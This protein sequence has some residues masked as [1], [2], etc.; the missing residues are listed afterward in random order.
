MFVSGNIKHTELGSAGVRRDELKLGR[1]DAAGVPAWLA[2]VASKLG[3][4]W[5]VPYVRTALR[6]KKRER[7][8][9]WL[10]G[11]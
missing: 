9:Q 10:A 11:K 5:G 1:C 7:I 2:K 8:V 6:G 4:T 3:I